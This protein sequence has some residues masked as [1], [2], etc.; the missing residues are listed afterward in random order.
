MNSNQIKELIRKKIKTI[1]TEQSEQEMRARQ[2]SIE[3]VENM[4][5]SIST[6]ILENQM[7]AFNPEVTIA[8]QRLIDALEEVVEQAEG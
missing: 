4:I 2:T 5:A 7:F 6:G 8:A 3:S 1:I